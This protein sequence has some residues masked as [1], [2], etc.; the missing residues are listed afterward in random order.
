MK[1]SRRLWTTRSIIT[2][3]GKYVEG[4]TDEANV[5][6]N[7]YNDHAVLGVVVRLRAILP[8]SMSESRELEYRCVQA[9][10]V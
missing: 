6:N 9:P 10:P 7:Y 1:R 4:E 5:N 8:L 3:N 2:K